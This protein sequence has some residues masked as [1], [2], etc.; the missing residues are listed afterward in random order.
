MAAACDSTTRSVV[1]ALPASEPAAAA[2]DRLRRAGWRVY[3]ATSC[4][5]LR[6][7]VSRVRPEAVALAADG[8]DESGWLTCA[9]LLRD[10]PHLRVILVGDPPA[11]GAEYAR[12][13]GAEALVPADVTADE[14]ADR[15]VGAAT[16]P[17]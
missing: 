14:L 5:D 2:A 6:R 11:D 16:I 12:F 10:E 1:L 8:F 17:G 15:V 4:A 13:V 3:R 7:L 9:K